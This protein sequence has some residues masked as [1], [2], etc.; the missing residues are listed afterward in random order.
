M[1]I[2]VRILI[3]RTAESGK[4][5]SDAGTGQVLDLPVVLVPTVL[6]GGRDGEIADGT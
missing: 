2:V 5:S 3:R 6:P 1:R 4:S